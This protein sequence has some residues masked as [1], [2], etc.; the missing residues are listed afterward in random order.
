MTTVT[1]RP[2]FREVIRFEV[3]GVDIGSYC[4][5]LR[6]CSVK[7]DRGWEGS[8]NYDSPSAVCDDLPSTVL[9]LS[10]EVE[11]PYSIL[12]LGSDVIFPAN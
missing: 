2:I 6:V 7:Q 9:Q 12:N 4:L 11:K 10:H 1:R 8:F 5:G 3:Y